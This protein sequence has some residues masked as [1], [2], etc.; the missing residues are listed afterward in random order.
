MQSMQWSLWPEN[1]NHGTYPKIVVA[2]LHWERWSA[3]YLKSRII[4]RAGAL[5]RFVL[6]QLT[7]TFRVLYLWTKIACRDSTDTSNAEECSRSH[8]QSTTA[9]QKPLVPIKIG[10]CG[11]QRS[12]ERVFLQAPTP[13]PTMNLDCKL[14]YC[15]LTERSATRKG[16]PAFSREYAVC[17][18]L[19]ATARSPSCRRPP[20]AN[21]Y[22]RKRW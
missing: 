16:P 22:Q 7:L 18:T 1:Q 4:L 2:K 8:E 10:M 19:Q 6:L 17:C 15:I 12:P 9:F 11:G 14:A 20:S 3:W 13:G 5:F 21:E